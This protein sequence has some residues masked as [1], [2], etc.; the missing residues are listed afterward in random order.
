M[1]LES[2]RDFKRQVSAEV[3]EAADTP[4]AVSFFASTE[5]P[6]PEG[7]A[8]GVAIRDDGEHVLAIR[9]SNEEAALEMAARVG[10]EADVKILR[11]RARVTPGW[12]E[13]RRRPVEPGV[14]LN[15]QGAG[16]VGTLGA[17]VRD[18]RG[19]YGLSN[20]HVIADVGATPIGTAI[21]QPFGDAGNLIGVLDRHVPLSRSSPNLVDCALL[22]FNR[23]NVLPT[24]NGALMGN[25]QG[26]RA[27]GPEDLGGEV[28]KIGRTTGVR[29]G[30][31]TAVE[32]DGLSVD[33]G[34][35]GVLRFNR[36]IEVSGG[37]AADFSAGGDSGSLIV[38]PDGFA[39][40]L[41]FAGGSD[42]TEDFTFGNPL[43][44]VLAALGVTLAT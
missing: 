9:S 4:E 20:S 11:V 38:R 7:M 19:L 1:N 23:V 44:L 10:G 5:P 15:I 8:L 42:G 25:V 18:A 28:M 33:Y 3:I 21:G 27:I 29:R 22:R 16:F 13:S 24:F 40:A 36:Q 34:S 37:P 41:L 31:I 32:V 17:V 14:Q 43:D 2:V 12:L 6:M 30:R 35:A 26:V 39:V